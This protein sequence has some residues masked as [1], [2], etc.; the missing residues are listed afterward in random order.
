MAKKYCPL[1]QNDAECCGNQCAWWIG[2]M[3]ATK[4]IAMH[5]IEIESVNKIYDSCEKREC[6]D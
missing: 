2:E 6:S 3:C 1:N 5:L 4:A